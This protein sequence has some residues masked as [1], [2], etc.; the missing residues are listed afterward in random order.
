M[1]YSTAELTINWN[2]RL[3]VDGKINDTS[4]PIFPDTSSYY[5]ISF[6]YPGYSLRFE[7]KYFCLLYV[8]LIVFTKNL[9][10]VHRRRCCCLH[11]YLSTHLQKEYMP[12]LPVGATTSA[13][14]RTQSSSLCI[15]IDRRYHFYTAGDNHIRADEIVTSQITICTITTGNR[16][17]SDSSNAIKDHYHARSLHL[18]CPVGLTRHYSHASPALTHK[19][20][21][22]I[23]A[24]GYTFRQLKMTNRDTDKKRKSQPKKSHERFSSRV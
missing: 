9:F 12:T 16:N 18:S 15:H 23:N 2:S 21:R 14:I 10:T 3:T 6:V 19:V 5:R 4:F 22:K 17:S 8:G 13:Q 1:Y 20:E 7:F 24:E 11:C